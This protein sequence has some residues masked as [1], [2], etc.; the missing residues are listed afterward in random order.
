MTVR[1]PAAC[2]KTVQDVA[3]ARPAFP[4]SQPRGRRQ[5]CTIGGNR[6]PTPA[7]RVVALRQCARAVPR[8]GSGD[9]RGRGVGAACRPAAQNNT[10]YD[11]R[12]L[13]IGSEG[14]L[15]VITAATLELYPQPG[16]VSTALA[17]RRWLDDAV[18][19]LGLAQ[20]RLGAALTGFEVMNRFSL[21][22]G[23][24]PLPAAPAAA[25][26]RSLD[27][28]ARTILQRRRR[29][30]AQRSRICSPPPSEKG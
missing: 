7:W 26:G 13:F 4:F 5:R 22:A 24:A 15:G 19:F 25:A 14:T 6:R 17:A 28:A 10:G 20:A 9:G 30:A 2:C 3:A 18:G 29:E 8:P 27:G 1:G 12:D 16:T 11:L 21:E 23:A